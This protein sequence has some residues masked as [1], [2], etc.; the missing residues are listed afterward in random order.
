MKF[1]ICIT[2]LTS[3]T[4]LYC[5][6]ANANA[7]VDD[8]EGARQRIVAAEQQG[9]ISKKFEMLKLSANE[10]PAAD[11]LMALASNYINNKQPSKAL[12]VLEKTEA[13]VSSSNSMLF[14]FWNA[15][16]SEA[17]V[18][19]NR[20]CKAHSALIQAKVA[21]GVEH[22]L[23]KEVDLAFE[24]QRSQQALDEKTLACLLS[25]TRS[26]FD[27]GVGIRPS[28]NISVTFATDSEL[29]TELGNQQVTK[30]ANILSNS[31]YQRYKFVVVGHADTRGDANY[32]ME[33][34][35]RRSAQV[36]KQITQQMPSLQGRISSKGRGESSPKANGNDAKSH[37]INRRVEVVLR[38]I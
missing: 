10:C 3:I 13:Y 5:A 23:V 37:A 22:A 30:L 28:I 19:E 32:N 6:N 11:T 14:G 29:P 33:L 18:Q 31:N 2:L 24:F 7:N 35:K 26:A 16:K 12:H 4:F 1:F 20:L 34:S 38:R 25:A 17:Y 15:L 27:R 9:N 8:C 36:K 21:L